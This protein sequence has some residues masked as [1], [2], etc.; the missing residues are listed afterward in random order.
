M[1]GTR[2]PTENGPQRPAPAPGAGP[3]GLP[4]AAPQRTA[5][6]AARPGGRRDSR[7][8]GGRGPGRRPGTGTGP[9]SAVTRPDTGEGTDA[10]TAGETGSGTG[11]SGGTGAAPDAP[12]G[13]GP[14]TP[15]DRA[16]APA[17]VVLDARRRDLPAHWF[18][19]RLLAVLSGRRPVHWML[20]HALGEA[21]DQLVRIADG[22]PLYA[23]N[24][25]T[26]TLRK[27]GEF[28]PRPG[29]I[30]AFAL[31]ACG[32]R[33]RAMAFRLEQS[34]EDRRWRCAA[35]DLGDREPPPPA[36]AD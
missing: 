8:P 13:T 26:P 6:G 23:A 15:A 7:R 16:V 19:E 14:V 2:T 36:P 27:C 28:R 1:D 22:A 32:D 34:P 31:I 5:T 20:G 18:A 9:A 29:V 25:R 33:L 11:V 21:Y 3:G 24:R 30:E 35:L 10:G 17:P 12:G 4:R